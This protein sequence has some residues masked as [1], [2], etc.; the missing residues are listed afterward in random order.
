MALQ[1]HWIKMLKLL[2]SALIFIQAAAYADD[3][4]LGKSVGEENF[5]A[6]SPRSWQCPAGTT[7][8]HKK[9]CISPKELSSYILSL[10]NNEVI[11]ERHYQN[12]SSETTALS[13]IARLRNEE[14]RDREVG[15]FLAVDMFDESKIIMGVP[16][17]YVQKIIDGGFKNLHQLGHSQGVEEAKE[18]S[19]MEDLMIGVRLEKAYGQSRNKHLINSIRPKYAFLQPTERSRRYLPSNSI[20]SQYGGVFFVFK[21]SVKR[22]STFT[23]DDSLCYSCISEHRR[24]DTYSFSKQLTV[25]DLK[26]DRRGDTVFLETQIWGELSID[27]VE[28]ALVNCPKLHDR[29]NNE[30]FEQTTWLE[31]QKMKFLG[32]FDVYKC[33][34]REDPLTKFIYRLD[35]GEK[36]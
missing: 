16:K 22:R 20:I 34:P 28:Y 31:I 13:L 29:T 1:K 11:E 14:L 32:R 6:Q 9:S 23:V 12:T 8:F 21:D 17:K 25:D 5:C 30:A 33:V 10:T 26:R 4:C 36:L 18:R 15:E 27:D 2:I 3:V 35:R 24:I 7:A 19:Q